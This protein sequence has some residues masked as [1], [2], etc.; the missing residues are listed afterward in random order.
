MLEK[1]SQNMKNQRMYGKIFVTI[2][3]LLISAVGFNVYGG[4]KRG[5]LRKASGMQLLS[6][7]QSKWE[8]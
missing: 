2:I 4:E 3:L 7:M 5:R 1:G 6:F 8:K